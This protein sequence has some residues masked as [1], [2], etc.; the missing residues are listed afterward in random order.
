[1]CPFCRSL[2]SANER[3]ERINKR[4]EANEAEAYFLLGV[5]YINGNDEMSVKQDQ[6]KGVGL[7]L[8][9]GELGSTKA[10]SQLACAYLNGVGVEQMKRRQDIT[11]SLRQFVV[12]YQQGTICR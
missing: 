6:E 9:S 5:T 2:K 11:L 7:F 1:M 3:L 4:I 8:R 10:Y 12:V